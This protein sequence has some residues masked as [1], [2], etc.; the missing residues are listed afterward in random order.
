MNIENTRLVLDYLKS[1]RAA[2]ERHWNMSHY[3]STSSYTAMELADHPDF[4]WDEGHYSGLGEPVAKFVGVSNA[5]HESHNLPAITDV[6]A[7]VLESGVDCGSVACFAGHVAIGFMANPPA[8]W[9][10]TGLRRQFNNAHDFAGEFL[11]MT[12]AESQSHFC[13]VM[14]FPIPYGL[15]RHGA[16]DAGEALSDV[17]LA[18]VIRRI[19]ICL[20]A[21]NWSVPG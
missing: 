21:E 6:F 3:F 1:K 15:P 2:I 20:A 16:N 17:T 8:I 12:E 19:E 5:I 7:N 10:A 9:A 4:E 11:G 18:D 13:H 14:D